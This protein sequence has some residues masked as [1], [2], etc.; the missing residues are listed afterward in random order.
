MLKYLGSCLDDASDIPPDPS[1]SNDSSSQISTGSISSTQTSLPAS[2]TSSPKGSQTQGGSPTRVAGADNNESDGNATKK[3]SGYIHLLHPIWVSPSDIV[4]TFSPPIAIIA[5]IA[6][7]VLVIIVVIGLFIFLRKRKQQRH[8]SSRNNLIRTFGDERAGLDA[9]GEDEVPQMAIP[10]PFV[11]RPVTRG[12]T[13]NMGS[14]GSGIRRNPTSSSHV[15]HSTAGE[16]SLRSP[17]TPGGATPSR[18]GERYL[19]DYGAMPTPGTN[20]NAR[21]QDE[22]IDRLAAKMVALMSS[23]RMT[24]QAWTPTMRKNQDGDLD[25]VE[26]ELPQAAPPMYNEVTRG[27]PPP[28]RPTEG[29]GE[30]AGHRF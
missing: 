24:D 4:Y 16:G 17:T 29:G 8:S 2:L 15:S 18:K 20:S 22:D 26:D 28:S 25:F 5:G 30:E 13:V 6:I 11:Y 23:G 14:A 21:M 7:G 27:N 19:P 10:D 12:Q 3:K 9:P 1:S